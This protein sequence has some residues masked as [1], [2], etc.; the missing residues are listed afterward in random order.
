MALP[1]APALTGRATPLGPGLESGNRE[2]AAPAE[3]PFSLRQPRIRVLGGLYGAR[4]NIIFMRP[5][6]LRGQNT[7]QGRAFVESE[8]TA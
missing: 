3:R 7:L 4:K 6:W 5:S 1:S 2:G 8:S